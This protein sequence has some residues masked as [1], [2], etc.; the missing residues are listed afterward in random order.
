MLVV[1]ICGLPRWRSSRPRL[2]TIVAAV[3]F[4]AV[5][6]LLSAL[7]P[8]I[9]YSDAWYATGDVGG[10]LYGGV[11]F[12][13][14][15]WKWCVLPFAGLWGAYLLRTARRRRRAVAPD[16]SS[17]GTTPDSKPKDR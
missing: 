11:F 12:G 7:A 13:M 10:G 5:P 3:L 1:G 15:A 9:F 4:V 16:H 6:P 14:Q 2:R 8:T 17:L